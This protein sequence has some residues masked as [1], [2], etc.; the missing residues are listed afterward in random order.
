MHGMGRPAPL[1]TRRIYTLVINTTSDP[2]IPIPDKLTESSSWK[3]R[4]P[5]HGLRGKSNGVVM[6]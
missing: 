3:G 6:F 4:L 5:L 2:R 1:A